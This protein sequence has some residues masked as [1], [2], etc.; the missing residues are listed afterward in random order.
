VEAGAHSI[1]LLIGPEGGFDA[2]EV[3][4]ARMHGF[5]S[6]R[7]GPRVL[8]TETAAPAALAALQFARGD[9]GDA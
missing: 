1:A 7:L 4:L 2:E 3:T 9:L 5:N 8:R 6:C